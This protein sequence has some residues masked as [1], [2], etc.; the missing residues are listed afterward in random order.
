MSVGEYSFAA[1]NEANNFYDVAVRAPTILPGFNS[2]EAAEGL[3][4]GL[5]DQAEAMS[6]K[7]AGRQT[8][9]QWQERCLQLA[10]AA[11]E[12]TGFAAHR[13]ELSTFTPERLARVRSAI[14]PYV[15]SVL[16]A[17]LQSGRASIPEL[18]LARTVIEHKGI[19]FL[20]TVLD[21]GL[22]YEDNEVMSSIQFGAEIFAGTWIGNGRV[23][24]IRPKD[25]GMILSG[26]I[27]EQSSIRSTQGMCAQ[28]AQDF[29]RRAHSG[30]NHRRIVRLLGEARQTAAHR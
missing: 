18:R 2:A 12:R 19:S 16:P 17:R 29:I 3:L 23:Y 14:A 20:P 30:S 7:F 6:V 10:E 13:H 24:S 4:S 5:I 25:V 9:L 8:G 1:Y 27:F 28:R 22:A 21:R 15:G 11:E 26:A